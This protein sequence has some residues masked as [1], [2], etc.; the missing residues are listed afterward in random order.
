MLLSD[1]HFSPLSTRY[2]GATPDKGLV[3]HRSGRF[4]RR[5][6]FAR[7]RTWQVYR[8]CA[9]VQG[10]LPGAYH[11]YQLRRACANACMLRADSI[12]AVS[13]QRVL[14]YLLTVLQSPRE[15]VLHTSKASHKVYIFHVNPGSHIHLSITATR[16]LPN[17]NLG[18]QENCR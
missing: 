6:V 9:T 16:S 13:A 10:V 4:T 14:P 11:V 12:V 1:S 5:N 2:C 15:D 7:T 8:H 3:R 17:V 18:V